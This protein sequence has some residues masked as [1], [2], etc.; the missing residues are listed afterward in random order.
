[1]LVPRH[2]PGDHGCPST[3][4]APPHP[5]QDVENIV[6]LPREAAAAQQ[7]LDGEAPLLQVYQRL[8]VLEGTSIKAQA[9]LES[10]TQVNLKEAKNLNSYFQRVDECC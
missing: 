5:R 1:M 2:R 7:L 10:G 8:L 9:A 6:A 3:L 4:T